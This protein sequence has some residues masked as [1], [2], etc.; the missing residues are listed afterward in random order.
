MA[1]GGASFFSLSHILDFV[2]LI[3][4]NSFSNAS[5]F[6]S[7]DSIPFPSF[8]F[9][10]FSSISFLSTNPSRFLRA[11]VSFSAADLLKPP[12]SYHEACSR[13]DASVWRKAMEC[14]ITSLHAHNAFKPA[15]LPRGRKAIGV[16]WVYA[17]KYNPDGSIIHGKEKARLVAQCFSQ[18]PE[19]FD[20]TYA[21]V[22]MNHDD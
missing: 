13:P 19:D 11:P 9:F 17:F 20:E 2:S 6:S 3:D 18:R 1:H 10:D 12:E 5:S 22:A 15:S 16:H 7:L 21:P 8:L 4:Y 14:E